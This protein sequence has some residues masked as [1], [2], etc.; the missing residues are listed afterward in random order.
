VA[1]AARACGAP[2]NALYQQALELRVASD[3]NASNRASVDD[4]PDSAAGNG[5]SGEADGG[6]GD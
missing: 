2:R 5:G 6:D 1:L 4:A 3:G